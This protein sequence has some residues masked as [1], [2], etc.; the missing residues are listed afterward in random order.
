MTINRSDRRDKLVNE[1]ERGK[2]VVSLFLDSI[3]LQGVN[4]IEVERLD[5]GWG[6]SQ[7]FQRRSVKWRITNS[8]LRISRRSE[9][10]NRLRE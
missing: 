10:Q 4:R 1:D 2:C 3:T 9:K 7:R 5:K 6:F 8:P